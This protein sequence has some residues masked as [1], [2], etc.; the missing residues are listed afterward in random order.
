MPPGPGRRSGGAAYRPVQIATANVQNDARATPDM[1]R[2]HPRGVHRFRIH[3][4]DIDAL[5]REQAG[6]RPERCD[7]EC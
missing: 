4:P 1:A 7:C 2:E 3:P 6:G 5:L